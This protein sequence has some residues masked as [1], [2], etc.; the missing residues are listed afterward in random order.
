MTQSTRPRTGGETPAGALAL[1][2]VRGSGPVSKVPDASSAWTYTCQ[3]C[4]AVNERFSRYGRAPAACP[5]CIATRETL[6]HRRRALRRWLAAR[7]DPELKTCEECGSTIVGR[8]PTAVVCGPACRRARSGRLERARLSDPAKAIKAS[9]AAREAYKRRGSGAGPVPGNCVICG[10]QIVRRQPTAK[11]CGHACANER[12]RLR[13]VAKTATVAERAARRCVVCDGPMDDRHFSAATCSPACSEKRKRERA[14]E[15]QAR[16]DVAARL[17]SD[18]H[19]QAAAK[20]S[21]DGLLRRKYG[22][23]PSEYDRRVAMQGGN[24]AIC[25]RP[26]AESTFGLLVVDHDHATGAVR[27]LLCASCNSGIGLLGDAVEGLSRAIS[28]LTRAGAIY[29]DPCPDSRAAPCS[30]TVHGQPKPL[31]ANDQRR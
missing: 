15:W 17:N 13:Q 1:N 4:G 8:R 20:K 31:A 9:E 28:Y 10:K 16:P 14:A 25:S 26:A 24:C 18:E 22:I 29:A 11:V 21:R 7:P 30:L 19:K 2:L 12:S 5:D 6:R 3:E 23:E 27:G